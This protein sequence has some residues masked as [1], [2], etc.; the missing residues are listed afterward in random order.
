E[1]IGFVNDL[2]KSSKPFA[3]QMG[4]EPVLEEIEATNSI[5]VAAQ[6]VQFAI[7][8]QLVRTL[9]TKQEGSRPP[10]RILRLRTTDAVNIAQVL[11][12]SY[13]QRPPDQRATQ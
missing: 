11:Q 1:V 2:V 12:Q 6:P 9:D 10:L 5:L 8:D 7:I 3:Q 4:A 13:S